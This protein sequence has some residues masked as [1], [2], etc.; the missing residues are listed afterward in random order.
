MSPRVEK[1]IRR[2]SLVTAGIGVVFSPIPLLDELVLLPIYGVMAS[3]IGKHHSLS[4]AAMPWRP[5]GATAVAG[6]AARAAVNLTV[7]YVP[8]L[9]A[10]ANAVS[11]LAL[12]QFLGRYVDEACAHPEDVK[13]LRVKEIMSAMRASMKKEPTKAPA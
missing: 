12:T 8:G 4:F 6:L 5:I 10:V 2:T 7:S 9:A 13:A 1:L 3:R 11:A